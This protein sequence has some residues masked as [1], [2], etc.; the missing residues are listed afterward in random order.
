MNNT[1]AMQELLEFADYRRE[2]SPNSGKAAWNMI[3]AKIKEE[4][5]EKQKSQIIDAYEAANE[6]EYRGVNLCEKYD[7]AEDYYNKTYNK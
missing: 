4:L 7:S 3:I 1:T 6:L 2:K 5:I